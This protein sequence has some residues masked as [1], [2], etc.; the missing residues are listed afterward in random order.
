MKKYK[1]EIPLDIDNGLAVYKSE[2]PLE[3]DL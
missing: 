2:I 1:N 3:T